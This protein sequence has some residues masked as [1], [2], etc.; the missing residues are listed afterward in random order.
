MDRKTLCTIVIGALL[1][2]SA[3]DADSQSQV[4]PSAN[5][6]LASLTTPVDY[7][8]RAEVEVIDDKFEKA[9]TFLG[10]E[11]TFGV[12]SHTFPENAA[13]LRSWVN[14]EETRIVQ[15]QLYI[16]Q[17]YTGEW[18]NYYA[19]TDENATRLPFAAIARDVVICAAR[20]C[21]LSETFGARIDDRVLRRIANIGASYSVK[22]RAKSGVSD[23]VT[24]TS[25]MAKA[26]IDA[27]DA[28]IGK[29][30]VSSR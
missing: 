23:I 18:R 8:L 26:Q 5:L 2:A 6:R 19:V 1:I 21:V 28:Y 29:L 22:F 14:K 12:Q 30:K 11:T 10:I 4:A 13:F 9:A 25:E 20:D 24:I 15:H 27:I 3:H 7:K 16:Y 17:T